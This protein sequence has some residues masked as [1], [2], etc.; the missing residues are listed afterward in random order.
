MEPQ[1]SA[2]GEAAGIAA[3]LAS[4]DGRAVASLPVSDVQAVLRSEGVLFTVHDLC[5]TTPTA[6][7]AAGGY[8]PAT[9]AALPVRP[10]KS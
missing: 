10:R 1:Y 6:W 9:C 8:D 3:A 2:L 7:R 4:R 5:R